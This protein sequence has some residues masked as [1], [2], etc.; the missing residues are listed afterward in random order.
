MFECFSYQTQPR[1]D[2]TSQVAGFE[3]GKAENSI[4]T[5]HVSPLTRRGL[6]GNTAG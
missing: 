2:W 6:F 4:S 1:G 3:L 5:G